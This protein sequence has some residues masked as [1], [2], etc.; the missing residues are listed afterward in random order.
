MEY[1]VSTNRARSEYCPVGFWNSTTCT[2]RGPPQWQSLNYSLAPVCYQ[3]HKDISLYVYYVC[4]KVW[5][6]AYFQLREEK[7]RVQHMSIHLQATVFQMNH[8]QGHNQVKFSSGV[9][10]W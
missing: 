3:L 7:N 8:L 10:I 2:E 9:T 6:E 1:T 4:M 5:I